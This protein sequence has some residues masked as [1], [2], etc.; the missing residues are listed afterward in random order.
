MNERDK[1]IEQLIKEKGGSREDYLNLLDTIAYHESAG[2]MDSTIKQKGGGPGR[3][4]YQFEEGKNAGGITAARRTKQY[5]KDNGMKVPEWL[6]KAATGD[7][8]DVTQLSSEQQD[9]LFLGNMRKHPKADLGKVVNGKESVE[10]FWLNYHWAGPAKEKAERAKSFE[11]S[12]SSLKAN[13]SKFAE[14]YEKKTVPQ[15][16]KPEEPSTPR[17]TWWKDYASKGWKNYSL[18][19]GDNGNSKQYLEKR[20]QWL[21]YDKKLNDYNTDQKIKSDVTRARYKFNPNEEQGL[22]TKEAISTSTYTPS[23]FLNNKQAMGGKLPPSAYLNNTNIFN[24]GGLH[25]TN[26]HG[27]IPQGMGANGQMNTVEQGEVSYTFDDGK[28]IFSNRL[29]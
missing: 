6:N 7:S 13:A 28:Y 22:N 8:L 21:D 2:T 26:P 1:L 25:E 24:V 12:V 11:D 4:K 15:G 14:H 19:S 17:P 20:N 3:G 29:S 9:A 18:I 10:D 16:N 23:I 27:G 5:Y